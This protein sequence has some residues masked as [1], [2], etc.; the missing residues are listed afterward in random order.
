MSVAKSDLAK[1]MFRVVDE[2]GVESCIL[3]SP[4][5]AVNR[6]VCEGKDCTDCKIAITFILARDEY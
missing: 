5:K 3:I 2:E 1:D 4:P 6:G